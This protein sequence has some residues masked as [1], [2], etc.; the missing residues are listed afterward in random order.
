MAIRRVGISGYAV[1]GGPMSG[2]V[3][4]ETA[5]GT[6]SIT[7]A[8]NTITFTAT[9]G[10]RKRLVAKVGHKPRVVHQTEFINLPCYFRDGDGT[11]IDPD[12]VVLKLY[13]PVG[14]TTTYTYGTDSEFEKRKTG[15]YNCDFQIGQYAGNWRYAWFGTYD[16]RTVIK[17]GSIV[18]Q[19]SPFFEQSSRNAYRRVSY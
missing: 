16:S 19:T 6:V 9:Y 14:V 3:S 17:E 2:L 7:Q 13:S 4:V 11:L 1:S 10:S 15:H 12:T 8:D 5:D 18:V